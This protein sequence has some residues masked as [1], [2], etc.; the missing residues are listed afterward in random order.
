MDTGLTLRPM[1]PD[2]IDAVAALEAELFPQPWSRGVFVD[3]LSQASRS[4]IVAED[5]SGTVVGYGGILV[6]GEDAHI[7]T[8]AVAVQRRNRGLG[9]RI[10]LRL[11]DT[12]VARGAE[13]L[14]LEVRPSNEPARRLYSRFG[15]APVGVR[16]EYY[17]D[18][19]AL[20]MW[21][22]DILSTDYAD[23]LALLREEAA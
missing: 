12:A 9:T 1:T 2:D 18:E 13:H 8:V 4:Y 3:E 15:F 16:K 11:V 23:R 5:D 6:I 10:M 17:V 20:V 21:A 22:R 19:D 14:T 7:T